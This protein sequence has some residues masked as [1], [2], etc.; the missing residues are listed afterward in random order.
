MTAKTPTRSLR[1]IFRPNTNGLH[2]IKSWKVLLACAAGEAV[3]L[4]AILVAH[5]LRPVT[6]LLIGQDSGHPGASARYREIFNWDGLIPTMLGSL[7]VAAAVWSALQLTA[8]V[9]PGTAL[10][11]AQM[12]LTEPPS[13]AVI[14]L[15]ELAD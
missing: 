4:Y 8:R 13:R 6:A 12:V 2:S 1:S 15:T 7:F 14:N 3:L 10:N 9:L 5:S 11:Q